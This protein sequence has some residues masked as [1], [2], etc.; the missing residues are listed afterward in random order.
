MDRLW[1]N[2]VAAVFRYQNFGI[3]RIA[4]DLLTQAVDVCLQ[5]MGRDAGIITPD[6]LE[7]HIPGDDLLVGSIEIFD[8]RSF[9][10]GKTHLCAPLVDQEFLARD[11]EYRT[12]K[13]TPKGWQVLRSQGVNMLRDGESLQGDAENLA[14]LERHAR[15]F[16]DKRLPVLQALGVVPNAAKA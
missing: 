2:L 11:V 1:N 13:I 15:S 4:L 9:F 6:L 3:G 7:Q 8:D 16:F 10:L 5:R 14:E 12:L